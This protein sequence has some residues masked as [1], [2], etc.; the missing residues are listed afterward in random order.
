[1]YQQRS[2]LKN[3]WLGQ[4]K[5][6]LKREK[7]IVGAVYFN[8][9]LTNGLQYQIIG[10]LDWAII[11][12]V[13][14][15]FYQGFWDLYSSANVDLQ[16]LFN[17]F[18]VMEMQVNGKRILTSL[19]IKLQLEEIDAM[20]TEKYP[21]INEKSLFYRRLSS[22]KSSDARFNKVIELLADAYSVSSALNY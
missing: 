21:N 12:L 14:G 17:L 19:P 2:D 16:P 9:D 6:F 15:K 22:M 10:E 13:N 18:G 11:N 4:L 5:D 20:V 3:L 8:V 1:M 7:S